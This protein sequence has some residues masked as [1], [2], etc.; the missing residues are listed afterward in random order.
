MYKN[1]QKIAS[2]TKKEGIM[3]RRIK[4]QLHKRTINPM[5]KH[6]VDC[7]YNVDLKL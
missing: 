4:N 1:N 7:K 3:E 6:G 2:I 5:L